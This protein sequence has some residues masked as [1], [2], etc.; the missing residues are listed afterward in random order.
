MIQNTQSGFAYFNM[1]CAEYSNVYN[2]KKYC[3][4]IHNLKIILRKEKNKTKI[5]LLRIKIPLTSSGGISFKSLRVTSF[6]LIV[7][8]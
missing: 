1:I 7:F 8:N 2:T 6:F 4:I 3:K 5:T